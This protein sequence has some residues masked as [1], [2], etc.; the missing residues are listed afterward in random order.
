MDGLAFMARRPVGVVN[1]PGIG[2]LRLGQLTKLVMTK[3]VHDARTGKR[4][5]LDDPR[6]LEAMAY[7]RSDDY[8]QNGLELRCN[9]PND[10]LDFARNMV[11]VDK[12]SF[13][14]SQS[15][16][17]TERRILEGLPG[18]V[19]RSRVSAHFPPKWFWERV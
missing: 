2:G 4:L 7:Y 9:S 13:R 5:P 8:G 17:E 19:D 6:R 12:G 3:D 11:E 14:V 16:K 18:P 15:Q 10:L 1:V